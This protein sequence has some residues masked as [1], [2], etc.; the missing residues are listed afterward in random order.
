M[1][2][3]SPTTPPISCAP[4]TGLQLTLEAGLA[5][6]DD[7]LLRPALEEALATTRRLHG[8]VEEVLRLSRSPGLPGTRAPS[9]P[10]ARLLRETEE[11]WHGL[12]AR[13]G[14]R[15][16]CTTTGDTPDDIRVPGAP[17]AEILGILLDNARV[18]GRG[19]VHLTVRDLGDAL[20]FDVADGGHRDTPALR[21][22]THRGRRGRG[23]RPRP[24][25]GPHRHPR[26]QTLPD[27]PPPHHLHCAGPGL[28]GRDRGQDRG[29]RRLRVPVRPGGT[30]DDEVQVC[31]SIRQTTP[32]GTRA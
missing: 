12:F 25:P 29:R 21:A 16:L 5:Q 17:V 4:L 19:T 26:R 11:H 10:V 27:G 18:H 7:S 30:P 15:L 9:V 20:A 8:T 1:N 23:D 24:C 6:D 28:S 22:R 3:T 2:G 31:E 14:R 32:F 13:D